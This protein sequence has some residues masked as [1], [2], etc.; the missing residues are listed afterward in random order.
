MIIR[1][2]I[3]VSDVVVKARK[4]YSILV[5]LEQ[6]LSNRSSFEGFPVTIRVEQYGNEGKTQP[7]GLQPIPDVFKAGDDLLIKGDGP[8]E[9]FVR[10]EAPSHHVPSFDQQISIIRM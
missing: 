5:H 7:R 10:S 4:P 9:F 8:F 1:S 2:V 6:F 3:D